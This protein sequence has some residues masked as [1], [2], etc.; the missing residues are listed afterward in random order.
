[1]K[2]TIQKNGFTLISKLVKANSIGF[3][4]ISRLV[5]ANPPGF[6]LI[7]LLVVT[8]IL[9]ILVGISSSV[10]VGILRSQNKTNAT[11]EVRQNAN[12]VIDFFERDI[13]S[14]S[15]IE[16]VGPLV[17]L[18]QT[19][20]VYYN[21]IKVTLQDGGFVHWICEDESPGVNGGLRRDP[22]PLDANPLQVTNFDPKSG[23]NIVC[24]DSSGNGAFQ[25]TGDTGGNQLVTMEFTAKQGVDAPARNDYQIELKFQ[26]TLGTRNRN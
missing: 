11:N 10:F 12:L 20:E 5:K 18:I 3:T 25:L 13:R 6:T 23:V 1:M 17:P 2:V 4:L 21:E 19:P 14:A 24:L 8:A 15:A 16:S 22:D 9:G 26:T 7:E